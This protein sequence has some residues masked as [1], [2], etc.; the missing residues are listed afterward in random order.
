M[1]VV[2]EVGQGVGLARLGEQGWLGGR[3]VD[4]SASLYV[5]VTRYS[6]VKV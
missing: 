2:R 5:V 6:Y 4:G 1:G 3:S